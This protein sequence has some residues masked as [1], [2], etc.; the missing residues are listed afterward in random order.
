VALLDRS[1]RHHQE[2]VDAVSILRA[3]LITCEAVIAESCYLLRDIEGAAAAVLENV[4]RGIF[5]IP[6]RLTGN[7]DTVRKLMRK[8]ADAPM[9]FAD[10]CLVDM[11]SDYRTGRIL[12]LDTDFRLYRWARNRPFELLLAL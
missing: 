12:T 9:D 6:Y 1:E 10:A 5:Q 4:A 8:Y 7:A 11:A 2:C 3:P